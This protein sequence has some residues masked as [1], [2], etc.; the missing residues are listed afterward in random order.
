ML[1]FYIY[2]NEKKNDREYRE[3]GAF[4]KKKIIYIHSICL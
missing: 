3:N 2:K 4:F 1:I